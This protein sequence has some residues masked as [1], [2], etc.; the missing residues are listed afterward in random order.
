MF[1]EAP[2]SLTAASHARDDVASSQAGL[3]I[4]MPHPCPP[5]AKVAA[6]AGGTQSQ[7]LL[8]HQKIRSPP[9]LAAQKR[10]ISITQRLCDTMLS[11]H[12]MSSKSGNGGSL[13]PVAP[14]SGWRAAWGLPQSQGLYLPACAPALAAL[15]AVKVDGGGLDSCGGAGRPPSGSS[16][17]AAALAAANRPQRLARLVGDCI[18]ALRPSSPDGISHGVACRRVL[19]RQAPSPLPF[20]L[21]LPFSH[22]LLLLCASPHTLGG[23]RS[24]GRPA[25]S[26]LSWRFWAGTP[27]W[28]HRSPLWSRARSRG[29]PGSSSGQSAWRRAW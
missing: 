29:H 18:M 27:G 14:G 24:R 13:A 5:I 21:T 9:Y 23:H 6:G 10:T 1:S 19:S 2:A 20:V 28:R 4:D 15:A 12:K 17:A 22:L 7:P 11:E 16:A 3:K 26:G 25:R 8:S